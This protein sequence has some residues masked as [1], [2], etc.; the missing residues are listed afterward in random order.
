MGLDILAWSEARLVEVHCFDSGGNPLGPDH[1]PLRDAIQAS[2]PDPSFVPSLAGLVA[3]AWYVLGG[4]RAGYRQS[5]GGYGHTRAVMCQAVIGVAPERVRDNLD[6]FAS[7]PLTPFVNFSDCEG[8]IGPRAAR[9]IHAAMTAEGV[10]DRFVD[11]H[12]WPNAAELYDD[13]VECF[14]VG[15]TGM[16]VYA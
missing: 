15:S 1:E 3:G 9:D 16:V 5:Y 14:R 6:Q 12:G 13:L 2:V 11:W 8:T 4:E 7:N 10:R